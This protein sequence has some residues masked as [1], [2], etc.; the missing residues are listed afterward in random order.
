MS[1]VEKYDFIHV[2]DYLEGEK[3]STIRHELIDGQAY[4]RS[5]GSSNHG[6]LSQEARAVGLKPD[7]HCDRA[8]YYFEKTVYR[9][10]LLWLPL[11]CLSSY[12]ALHQFNCHLFAHSSNQ[13]FF[14]SA[15][16]P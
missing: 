5:G 1:T 2:A 13:V 8:W 9:G 11:H 12:V 3:S 15:L 10:N 6:R 7:L 4:A 14:V 16:L